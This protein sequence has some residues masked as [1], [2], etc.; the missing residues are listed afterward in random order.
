M[1]L[2]KTST[3]TRAQALGN[4]SSSSQVNYFLHFPC[5]L[6]LCRTQTLADLES[7]IFELND[8][9]E[10]E[11][12][13]AI[14]RAAAEYEARP[15]ALFCLPPG[16]VVRRTAHKIGTSKYL[17]GI[18]IPV[19][20]VSCVLMAMEAPG[21]DSPAWMETWDR[22]ALA[23]FT[24]EMTIKVVDLGLVRASNAYLRDAW[25]CLD[26]FIVLTGFL[27]IALSETILGGD[28]SLAGLKAMRLIRT[29]RP[30]RLI[31]RADGLKE[32]FNCLVT[33]IP[34]GLQVSVLLSF[35]ALAFAVVAVMLFSG[36]FY[37][38]SDS[39][40]WTAAFIP[41]WTRTNETGV[42]T[43]LVRDWLDCVGGAGKFWAN[44]AHS[45]D[46]V[47]SS[48]KTLFE[49]ATFTF[50]AQLVSALM[51]K[52]RGLQPVWE[53]NSPYAIQ[54]CAFY[55]IWLVFGGLVVGRDF[56]RSFCCTVPYEPDA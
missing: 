17:D 16:H 36:K 50:Q 43:I 37:T 55:V 51:T 41:S 12:A 56:H 48:L 5:R 42:E 11:A 2:L 45:F 39:T 15:N 46:D 30:L 35:G 40:L 1:R 3:K 33:S 34:P 13:L 10:H 8:V 47:P 31:S 44:P 22:I 28:S 18:V 14:A 52:G 7:V 23:I 49:A 6:K 24:V 38:C 26:F 27:D 20:L 9:R 21:K 4:P 19:I 25:N 54:A 53:K 29:L 32:C